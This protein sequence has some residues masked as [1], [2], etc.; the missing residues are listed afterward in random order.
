MNSSSPWTFSNSSASRDAF[1]YHGAR[2]FL[3]E[4]LGRERDTK[5]RVDAVFSLTD[6]AKQ[7]AVRVVDSNTASMICFMTTSRSLGSDG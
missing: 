3:D 7:E 6:W 4:V 1:G 2:R 5:S